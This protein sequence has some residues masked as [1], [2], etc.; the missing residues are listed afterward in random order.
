MAEVEQQSELPT[1]LPKQR[2]IL[3]SV[4]MSLLFVILFIVAALAVMFSTDRGSKFLLDSVLQRQ[5][6]IHYEYES[7]NLLS[8]IILKNVLVTLESVDVKIDRADVSLGWRAIVNKEIHLTHADVQNL[9][10]ITKGPSSDEPFKY[11]EIRLPFILRVDKADVDKLAIHTGTTQVD[12]LDIHLEKALWSGT[13]LTFKNTRMD[14]GY[15][16]VK[17]ANGTMAFNQGTYPIQA[18]ADVN[19]PSLNDSLNIHGIYVVANGTLD[20]IEAGFATNTPDLLTGWGVVH[21]LRDHVPMKGELRFKNYHLPL[22]TDQKLFAKKGI[23]KYYGDIERLNIDLDTDLSGQDIP[24]GRYKASMYTDLINQLNIENLNGEILDGGVNISGIVSWKDHVTWDMTGHLDQIKPTDK[25]IPEVVRDFLPPSLDANLASTGLLEDGLHV[26][27]NIDFDKYETWNLKLDQKEEKSKKSEPMLM[28]IAWRGLDR[29]MPYI[30]WLKSDTGDV[31]VNLVNDQQNIYVSTI[32]KQHEKSSL[33]AGQ[34]SAQLNIKDNNLNVPNFSFSAGQ[35]SLKGSAFLALPTDKSLLKWNALLDANNFNPQTVA[36]AAPI[37]LL[38]GR[39]KANG[40]A[41]PNQQIIHLNPISLTGRLV[42]QNE[43]VRLTG[44]STAAILF[45][46]EKQGGAFKSFAVDYDGTLN[47]SGIQISHG[48]LKAKISGTSQYIKINQFSHNGVA[49]RIA[50]DG[51]VNLVH[52]VGWSI[53]ASL[54]RFKPQYFVSSVR[55]EVSGILKTQGRWSDSIKQINISQL[56]LAGKL[57]NKAIRGTGNLAMLLGENQNGLL[58]KQFE[59]NNLFLS[60]AQNQIQATG[61]AQNLKVNINAPAL[62]EIYS[63]LRGKA[64][65]YVNVQAQPKLKAT[66]NLAVDDFRFNDLLSVK[67]LRIQGELPTS[68]T[69]P[70]LLT[71]KIDSLRSGDREIQKGGI[72]IAGTRKA[73]ILK[74]KAENKLSEFYV[75]LAGG[76]NA[77]NDWLG[78]IQK[79]D[80]DSL[81]TRLVQKQNASVIYHSNN[82]EL[83][84]GAH[85]WMSQQSQLCFDQPIRVSKTKGNISF[86]TQNVDLSD[87]SAFMPDGLAITGKVNGYAKAAWSQGQKPKIDVK[88]LTRNG[89]IGITGDDPQEIG[90]NLKYDQISMIAKSI[91]DGLQLRLDVETPNIGRGYANVVIDPY[92]INKAMRGEIAFNEL[93]LKI[94]KPFIADVRQ[95]DGTLSFAGKVGGSLTKPLLTGE[96]RLKNGSI[97]MISLP[98]NLTNIQLYSSIRQNNAEIN[99]AFNSGRGVGKLKGTF[100]WKGEPKID[101]NLK[102]DNLFIRQAPIITAIVNTSISLTAF[103]FL[104]KLTVK[105]NVDIPRA[106]ISMPESTASVVNISPDVRVVYEGQDQLAILKAAKPWDIHADLDI[107][108]GKQVI[109]QGFDSR[110]PLTGR[111]YLTQRGSET[112]M[113]ANGAIGVSQRVKIEAYGQSLDLNRAIARFNGALSNPTLDVDAN[114]NIQG[115]LVG[116][117]VI[118]TASSPNIQIYNDAGLSE[119]EALNAIITGRINEGASGLSQTEGFKSDVN[120]TI[121]AAGISMGLGGTRALTNQ[122]GR[123]L[124]LSSLALDAQGTGDDTQVS[125]TGYITPDL[126]IRYGVGV[127]TPVNKLTLRYQMNQRLYMEASQSLER[128]VDFFYNWRF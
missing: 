121:A 29:E 125:L 72:S 127:F 107:S 55:G 97:S 76:F 4:F 104:N 92:S 20:T 24:E 28:N 40:Y 59:A 87:F 86:V 36:S 93:Q 117:R 41:K 80:F 78:Q 68:N 79:G 30:G 50:V 122:I 58:P 96:M 17:N 61:N 113:R 25:I 73:H 32:V 88:L 102:G 128:A 21:P 126:F 75:Q 109:F 10:I 6:I 48:H 83:F 81:R 82:G 66:A 5:Q 99:G 64:Y 57:N 26:T 114:K 89:V 43:S 1:P 103:P 120:N 44:K 16:N 112:A 90:S 69:T 77:N 106:L 11:D 7:G 8:G 111:L 45:N 12:F 62:Y 23:A 70:T 3:R 101:L 116:I 9:Q 31:K 74:V 38:N 53:N 52:G 105:G 35:G 49:G 119:Q 37:N 91:S 60:Y 22:L 2:R 27:A 13:Q 123:T 124:G 94:F 115:S 47:A 15:L 108:L 65:G 110:I 100:D 98:V 118:G 42:D 63:G 54:I 39:V 51:I 95:L 56:N 19:I 33:P 18:T 84:I 85:C 34:Y 67:K 46:D 14:M 71:A